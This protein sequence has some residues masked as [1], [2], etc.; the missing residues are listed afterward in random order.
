MKELKS[1]W[2]RKLESKN[3]KQRIKSYLLE[4]LIFALVMSALDV[5]GILAS[6]NG[7]VFYFLDNYTIN[8]II[9]VMITFI[10]LFIMAFILNYLATEK[11]LRK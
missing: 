9:T 2:G 7:A 6:K 3:K 5:I 4:S 8:F 11:Q 1:I 10:I